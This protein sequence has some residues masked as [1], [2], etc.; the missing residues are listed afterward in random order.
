M[1]ILGD[2][3]ELSAQTGR[4]LNNALTV[5]FKTAPDVTLVTAVQ[6]SSIG[7]LFGFRNGGHGRY[8]IPSDAGDVH[9]DCA[10]TATTVTRGDGEVIGSIAKDTGGS[11][12]LRAAEGSILAR[13]APQSKDKHADFAWQHP[14]TGPGGDPLGQLTWIRSRPTSGW[15]LLDDLTDMAV[16]WD[17][18]GEPLKVPSLGAHLT[19][20]RPVPADLGDLLVAACIDISIGSH[21]F[22]TR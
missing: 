2:A 3:T 13:A 5:T 8:T 12:L 20:A 21:S 11:G 14:L 10:V 1:G 6:A 18:A 9:V 15:D 17:R 7:V 4:K 22:V 16:W 19:L